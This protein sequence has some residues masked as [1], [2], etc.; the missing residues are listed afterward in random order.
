MSKHSIPGNC[1][2]ASLFLLLAIIAGCVSV[3][4]VR[5]VKPSP[6]ERTGSFTV[7]TYNIRVGYGR[8][9]PGVS[10]WIL[11]RAKKNLNPIIRAIASV[12]PDIVGLQEVLGEGQA[13][14]IAEGLNLNFAY[15]AHAG[16]GWWGLAILSKFPITDCL[17]RPISA[18]RRILVCDLEVHARK[19]TF[20]DVH[21][22]LQK[23]KSSV[24]SIMASINSIDPPIIV[25]GDFNVA[26]YDGRIDLVTE[27]FVDT[28]Y[29]VRTAAAVHVWT[30]G[31]FAESSNYR[32]DYVFIDQQNF[33]VQDVGLIA[34]AHIDASDHIG[35][36]AQISFVR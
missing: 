8:K 9:D 18:E 10:P 15:A 33:E 2:R 35:Y 21:K 14:Q 25:M 31:T 11:R 32:I 36:W 19:V 20:V 17:S 1:S 12:D 7:L 22:N 34:G 29:E 16:R 28:A 24:A 30:R 23:T 4:N 6:I 27:R 3:Q 13:R 5:T 26:P